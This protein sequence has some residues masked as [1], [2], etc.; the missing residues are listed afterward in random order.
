MEIKKNT[1]SIS[2]YDYE[3]KTIPHVVIIITPLT[4][5]LGKLI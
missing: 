4:S 1:R 2:V 3:Y 5:I